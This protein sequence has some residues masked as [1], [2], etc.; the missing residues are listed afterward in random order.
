MGANDI[1]TDQADAASRPRRLRR[2]PLIPAGLSFLW[3]GLGQLVL[4]R[5]ALAAVFAIPAVAFVVWVVLQAEQGALMFAASLWDG[6]YAATAIVI[7][8]LFGL[9]RAA[10][11]GHA[12]YLGLRGRRPRKFEYGLVAVLVAVIAATHGL[13]VAGAVAWYETAQSMQSNDLLAQVEGSP[14][15]TTVPSPTPT[16]SSQASPTPT[17]IPTPEPSPTRAPNPNRITFLIL[18]VDFSAGRTHGL[19]DTMMV[20]SADTGTG[21]VEMIS[22]PRDTAG[23]ELYFGGNA[24]GNFKLNTLLNYAGTSRFW[25]PDSPIDTLKKEIGYL[26]GIPINYYAL[27]DMD[28]FAKMIDAVGGVDVYLNRAINDPATGIVLTVGTWHLDGPG[29]VLYVRSRENGG[30][31][32]IRAGRQQGLLVA[33]ERK[34]TSGA[35]LAKFGTMLSL[36]GK[37]IATDFPLSTARN[38]VSVAQRVKAIDSCV[39]GPPYST[40]PDTSTTGGTWTSRLDLTRVANLSVQFFGTD[41]R[42]YDMPGVA[43]APCGK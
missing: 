42:Y 34:M 33:L 18:G 6:T 40:H 35:G 8:C 25:S 11:V 3:P 14:E 7:V 4:G 32:Y 24:P 20:V 15:P 21:K 12:F 39:L 38:Y 36:A 23:F 26:V 17:E 1:D 16:S 22:V 29:A 10:S 19:T 28:G 9:W 27:L 30:S 2:S 31:D 41:S 43:A 13:F 5:R 37:T